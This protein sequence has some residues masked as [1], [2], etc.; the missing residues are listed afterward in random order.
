MKTY[1]TALFALSVGTAFGQI[2]D[3]VPPQTG[4][5][6]ENRAVQIAHQSRQTPPSPVSGF[7]VVEGQP[8]HMAIVHFYTS[9]KQ[10]LRADT[11]TKK[12]VNLKNRAVLTKLNERLAVLLEAVPVSAPVAIR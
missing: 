12:W 10:E 2:T 6:T 4:T 3:S 1:L 11:L 7:W 8:K 9:N 5:W